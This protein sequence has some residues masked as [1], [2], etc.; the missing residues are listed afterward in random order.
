MPKMRGETD[1]QFMD[2][3]RDARGLPP[4]SETTDFRAEL[5]GRTRAAVG[6][7]ASKGSNTEAL[8]MAAFLELFHPEVEGLQHLEL[9]QSARA[10]DARR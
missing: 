2:R 9:M 10:Q 1:R 5:M 8:K 4:M 7:I 3:L 6:Y